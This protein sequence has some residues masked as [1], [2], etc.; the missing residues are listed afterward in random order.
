MLNLLPHRRLHVPHGFAIF[1]ALLLIVSGVVG[2]EVNKDVYSSNQ[3]TAIS[4]QAGSAE[5]ERV[6]DAVEN[7]SRGLKLGLLLF[8]R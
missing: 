7:K 6:N 5:S 4:T 1:A 8:R 2:Y 3:E